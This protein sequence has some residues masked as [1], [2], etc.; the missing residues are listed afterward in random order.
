MNFPRIMLFLGMAAFVW[1]SVALLTNSRWL[2]NIDFLAAQNPPPNPQ[3][4]APPEQATPQNPNEGPSQQPGE[5]AI[6]GPKK[7]PKPQPSQRISESPGNIAR[8][9][10]N[11][12][13]VRL[14]VVVTDGHG[15][16][17]PNLG[18]KN[19]KVF[20]EKV[21]QPISMF[22]PT[23]APITTV[24]LMEFSNATCGLMY[25]L[26]GNG[27]YTLASD[28]RQLANM[29]F[30]GLRPDDWVAVVA[31]D[32]RPEILSDFTQDKRNLYD[33]LR[34]MNIPAWSEANMFDALTDTLNRLDEVEGKKA[35][36]LFTTG[37]DTFSKTNFD[38]TLKKAQN[39][40]VSIYAVSFGAAQR[41]MS[42]PYMSS[43]RRMDFLQADNQLNAF[44]RDTGGK[45]YFPRFEGE[46][47]GIIQ[48]VMANLRSQYSIG[49]TPTNPAHDGKF[50]KVKVELV[51]PDGGPLTIKD[52]HGKTIKAEL[53]YRA[54]YLAPKG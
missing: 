54:G 35:I 32:I 42:D 9:A 40:D 52:Q 33:A 46:W 53:R 39:T 31:Y 37:I 2:G 36:L 49:Y 41:I 43:E 25:N 22:Q 19:F 15:T 11:V 23:Q 28:A 4:T 5:G 14:D 8:I 10:V 34:R 38:K 24:L 17:I 12:N 21:E 18:E 27:Y 6:K 29:F 51:A 45:A 7:K 20:E 48:D 47:P 1:V 13:L 44:A 30:Q 50:H 3:P 26:C 16:P